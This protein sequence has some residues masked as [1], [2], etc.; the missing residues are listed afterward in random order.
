MIWRSPEFAFGGFG[1][2]FG[3]VTLIRTD[4]AR[5]SKYKV[6]PTDYKSILVGTRT[7]VRA[8]SA[9]SK[10]ETDSTHMLCVTIFRFVCF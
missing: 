1:F 7:P 10:L 3:N 9:V 2:V 4:N 5:R 8:C 6:I